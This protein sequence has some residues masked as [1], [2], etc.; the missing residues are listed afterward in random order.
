MKNSNTCKICYEEALISFIKVLA[1]QGLWNTYL[2]IVNQVFLR[3]NYT[4]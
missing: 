2:Y 4:V 1:S 3:E